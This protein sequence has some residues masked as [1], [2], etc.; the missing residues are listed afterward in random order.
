MGALNSSL[1]SEISL[2]DLQRTKHINIL[3]KYN[4]VAYIIHAN[5][6]FIIYEFPNANI[7][8]ALAE[9]NIKKINLTIE[10][11]DKGK[12][13]FLCITLIKHCDQFK[14]A[15]I[16]SQQPEIVLYLIINDGKI[17]QPRYS[18]LTGCEMV[19]IR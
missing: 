2:Q 17:F 18:F 6:I 14:V 16:E 15:T 1:F 9:F 7:N 19:R 3:T 10:I 13:N 5:D 8:D 4:R 12:M 11:E